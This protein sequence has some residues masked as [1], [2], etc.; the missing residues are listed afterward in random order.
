MEEDTSIRDTWVDFQR[1]RTRAEHLFRPNQDRQGGPHDDHLHPYLR[2]AHDD[3]GDKKRGGV[4]EARSTADVVV[5]SRP[6][7]EG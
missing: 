2:L 4:S 7:L 1:C 3:W 6:V 5:P